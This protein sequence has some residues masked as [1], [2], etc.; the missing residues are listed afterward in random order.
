MFPPPN[1]HYRISDEEMH[2]MRLDIE[3]VVGRLD[4]VEASLVLQNTQAQRIE[5]NTKD[6]LDTF[7]A[8]Q[9]AWKVLNWIG[10]LA[11]PIGYLATFGAGIYWVKDHIK[12][13]FK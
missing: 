1:N 9:G 7:Q 5:T 10:K 12:D 4:K 13:V 6:L 8:F 3:G 11:K 2:K